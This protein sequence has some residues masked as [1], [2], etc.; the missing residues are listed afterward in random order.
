[1]ISTLT[2][3]SSFGQQRAY[4][5]KEIVRLR[6]NLEDLTDYLDLLEARARNRGKARYTTEEIERMLGLNER[7]NSVR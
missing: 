5:I 7:H 2:K 1:M 6:Q 3:P 4:V